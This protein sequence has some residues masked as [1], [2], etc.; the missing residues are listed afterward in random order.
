LYF[1]GAA[2]EQ[3]LLEIFYLAA[4]W[5]GLGFIG[6]RLTGEQFEGSIKTAAYA[7]G[8][9]LAFIGLPLFLA[10][11][12]VW[13]EELWQDWQVHRAVREWDDAHPFDV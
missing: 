4:I 13:I 1:S 12:P 5:A 2:H 7:G 3:P 9:I 6:A 10:K 11:I 8:A